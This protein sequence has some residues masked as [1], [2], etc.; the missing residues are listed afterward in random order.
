MKGFVEIAINNINNGTDFIELENVD[1]F[2]IAK[3]IEKSMLEKKLIKFEHS[4]G[5][6]NVQ[7]IW[8]NTHN[9]VSISIKN[10]KE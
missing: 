7:H 5:K 9:I 2:E 8:V 4:D 10:F 3:A 6:G 1:Y